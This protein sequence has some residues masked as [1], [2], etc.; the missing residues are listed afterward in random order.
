MTPEEKLVSY[1][2]AR[3]YSQADV[4]EA[5][6]ISRQSVSRWETGDSKPTN[7]NIL[8]LSKLYG[9]PF[10]LMIKD[11]YESTED[12]P[13]ECI[14][15]EKT[16]PQ[17]AVNDNKHSRLNNKVLCG[18]ILFLVIVIVILVLYIFL[19]S[20]NSAVVV[21]NGDMIISEVTPDGYSTEQDS[22]L[23]DITS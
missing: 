22:F 15:N 6:N 16:S 7:E 21:D 4:A 5:L 23:V 17:E 8:R 20:D 14:S 11:L 10:D 19:R 12:T 1:R 13:I 3:N 9:I 2:K 18:I